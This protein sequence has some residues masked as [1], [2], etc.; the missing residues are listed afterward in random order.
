V[1]ETKLPRPMVRDD[2]RKRLRAD[3][4]N[5]AV[6]LAEERRLRRATPWLRVATWWAESP[7]RPVVVAATLVVVLI[8]GAGT[9]AAGS[10]SGDATFVLKQAA[11]QMELALAPNDEAKVQVLATQAQRR[12]DELARTSEH[13]EKA[14]TASVAYEAAVVRFAAAVEALRTADRGAKREAVEHV[15]DAAHDK[16]IEVLEVL[17]DRLPE[18][19]QEKIERAIEEHEKLSPGKP[20]RPRSTERPGGVPQRPAETQRVRATETPRGGRPSLSPGA[21]PTPTQR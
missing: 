6:A 1:S 15:V 21:S 19:A 16:H 2:F 4:M 12:L 13:L 8:A 17:R 3:L 14:P 11:E 10:I 9:A 7:L 18:P 20:D 5:E